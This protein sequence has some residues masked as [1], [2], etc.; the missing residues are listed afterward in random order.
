MAIV[1]LAAS[2]A[3]SPPTDGASGA[4]GQ[5]GATFNVAVARPEHGTVTSA[6]GLIHCGTGGTACAADYPWSASVVLTATPDAGFGHQNWAGD[7][8][9][10]GPCVL[11]TSRYGADKY[12][13]AVFN[14]IDQLGHGNFTSPVIHGPAYHAFTAGAPGALQCTGCH[15]D[16]LQGRGL[17]VSC[18]ACHATNG[19]GHWRAS[20]SCTGCHGDATR[21][22]VAGADPNLSA[23]PPR[24]TQGNTASTA[25]G[26]GA[27]QAHVAS[28]L[29][30]KPI[31][32]AACHVVP[33]STGHANGVVDVT[34]GA[35]AKTGG[36]APS[37]DGASCSASYCHG[38]TLGGGTNTAPSWTGGASQAT[39][40]S[41][42]GLPP[43]APH[44]QST[45]CGGCHPGYTSTSVNP[46]TH[47]DGQIQVVGGST[48][49]SCHGDPTRTPLAGADPHV[50]AAP[51]VD[52]TGHTL[53]S[54]RGVG[55]HQAHVN[56]PMISNPLACSECH[57]V[58]SS[59]AHSD[60]VVDVTFG[61]RSRTG[62]A[63]PIWN[64]ASCSA[65]YCH[66]ATLGGGTNT[67]PS[68]TG[69]ASQATCGSC[70]GLPPPAP[71][72][73][74][75]NCGGCHAGYTATTVNPATH[76][77]GQ[78]QVAATSCTSCHGDATRVAVAGADPN[79]NAAP[80]ADT[81]GNVSTTA[82]GVGAHVAH[83]N[84]T[85]RPLA[86]SECHVVPTSTSHSDGVALVTFGPLARTGGASP[87]WD[88]ASCSASYCHGATLSGGT[89]TAPSWTGGASQA[90]CGACHGLPPSTGQHGRHSSQSCGNC[91]GGSY[92]RTT[93]DPSRHVNGSVEIG[94][95][96]TSWNRATGACVGCHGSA[97]W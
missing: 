40:G 67:A 13:V 26:V 37:W 71:H 14:P 60:G 12:V 30:A 35:V 85:D 3:K 49:T 9:M 47:V 18:D 74:S 75:T 36:A 5:A 50:A 97:T 44:T 87:A 48:C 19:Y 22:A 64:G 29:L 86:C 79:V 4:K 38:A 23:A 24:D 89:N 21:S 45:S 83:V 32:C 53:S 78:V 92:T 58:P 59:T 41:C 28:A 70:H 69:G 65:S 25:R 1:M 76:V 52:T 43:P 61:A 81:K 82:R 66:G 84:G 11:D 17:A 96:V 39:C 77:D 93:T 63:S 62:G 15:G 46:A 88:G 31:A 72:S 95:Q 33:S 91:H 27:H 56:V 8:S 68:W 16:D 55:A 7:C 73:Q 2:C 51:P 90:A 94:N 42:H 80:P 10:T 54:D 34:F 57:V 6:D 20:V